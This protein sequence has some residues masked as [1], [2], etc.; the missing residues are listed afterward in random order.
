MKDFLAGLVKHLSALDI[1]N[2]ALLY[3]QRA[4]TYTRLSHSSLIKVHLL[5]LLTL[6]LLCLF[7]F[8]N[9]LTL[10]KRTPGTFRVE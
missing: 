5:L 1:E 7:V 9:G 4:L 8:V 6:L 3:L 2:E 10:P